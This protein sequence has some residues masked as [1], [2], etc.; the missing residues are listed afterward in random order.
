[1]LPQ[2][3]MFY[4]ICFILFSICSYSLSETVESNCRHA[5]YKSQSMSMYF[6]KNED[7]F[8]FKGN[9]VYPS[10][11]VNIGTVSSVQF[12]RSV[13]SNSLRPH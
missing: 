10:Q 1:M 9:T 11:E 4:Y 2:M 12:S 3:L 5:A 8:L 7:I 6:L 13:V